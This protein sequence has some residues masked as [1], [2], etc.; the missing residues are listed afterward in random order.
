LVSLCAISLSLKS[1]RILSDLDIY[2]TAKLLI[3][4]HG[5]EA[6]LYAAARTAVHAGDDE[7]AAVWRQIIAAIEKVQC[8]R[9]PG[10]AL[11]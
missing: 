8:E 9:R 7:G 3:D 11:S 4:R 2:R 6:S 10:E 5:E 1:Y